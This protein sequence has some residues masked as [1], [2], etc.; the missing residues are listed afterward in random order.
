MLVLS[1]K[2][3]RTGRHMSWIKYFILSS[4]GRKLVMSLT[5]LFLI[6]FLVIHLA[7]NL[8][9]LV[10]DGGEAFNTYAY[11]MTH[12]PVIRI[13]SLGLYFFILVHA[14]QGIVIWVQNLRARPHKYAVGH[15][16][17]ASFVAKQMVLLG[18][19]I[20]AFLC[21]HLKDFW[22]K[23]KFTDTLALRQYTPYT[24]EVKDLYIPVDIAFHSPWIVI[25]YLVGLLA[26]AVHLWHGFGSAF[27]TLGL[28]HKRYGFLFHWIG[29]GYAILVP[30]GFAIIPLYIF[31]FR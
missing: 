18:I 20:F 29:R 22:Y 8:Q 11:L 23:M 4:P 26:L 19:L 1:G 17:E 12:N 15:Y 31:F 27:M 5:G 25:A 13:I 6:L 3:E 28:T 24:P 2:T 21:L 16:P 30:L 7:G 10:D 14:I 9:L